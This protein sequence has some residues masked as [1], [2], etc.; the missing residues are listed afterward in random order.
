MSSSGSPVQGAERE[1]NP[2]FASC[3][4]AAECALE[5]NDF[6][7]ALA[8][9]D[10]ALLAAQSDTSSEA[11]CEVRLIKSA[12]HRLLGEP[13]SAEPYARAVMEALTTGTALWCAAVGE[14]ALSLAPLGHH[15]QLAALGEAI[16]G[17]WTPE[18]SSALV[19]A[20][21]RVALGLTQR[22]LGARAEA[23]YE[24]IASVPTVGLTP[25]A[26]ARVHKALA[27]RALLAGDDAEYLAGIAAAA[28]AFT[29]ARDLRS[30]GFTHVAVGIAGANFGDF[31]AA[32]RA[33][34]EALGLARQINLPTLA[35]AALQNLA[36][37]LAKR[38]E[39]AEA[40]TSVREALAISTLQG[41]N[42]M[43]CASRFYLAM[44]LTTAGDFDAAEREA[45]IVV[46]ELEPAPPVLAIALG[47]LA[48]VHLAQHRPTDALRHASRAVALLAEIDVEVGDARIRLIHAEALHATGALEAARSAIAEARTR[49]LA[50]A[51]RIGDPALRAGFLERV[52][53][54]ARTLATAV[55]WGA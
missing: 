7:A 34:R 30:A 16:L 44:V 1:A 3:H 32:E 38:G 22:G 25:L 53:E 49:L 26:R 24:K 2:D 27:T 10:Q 45:A 43:I 6:T 51:A 11:L 55:S 37:V 5:C 23:L 39:I 33:F 46:E 15:E 28:D 14:L 19:I 8:S 18:P 9:A 17:C 31:A 41:N 21:E 48:D 47:I 50:R 40:L 4:S 29:R 42:R 20:S 52:P 35:A 13:A 12:A 54:N 36:P